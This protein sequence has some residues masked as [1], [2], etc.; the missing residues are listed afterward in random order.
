MSA[1]S[2]PLPKAVV[3]HVWNRAPVVAVLTWT[4]SPSELSCSE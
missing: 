3:T 1:P 4:F 2:G